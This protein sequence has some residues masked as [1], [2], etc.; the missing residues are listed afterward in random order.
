[1]TL[2]DNTNANTS[3]T[4]TPKPLNFIIALFPGFQ[5]LDLTGPLDILN[6][7]TL[8]PF[9]QPLTLTFL[10]TTLDPVPTKPIPPKSATYTYDLQSLNGTGEVGVGFNQ[11]ITPDA[12]FAG[13]LADLTADR[14]PAEKRPDILLIPGG[15]G[16]RL[17]RLTQTASGEE[18]S[19][20]IVDLIAW[21]PRVV[22]HLR[23]GIMTVCTGSDIL[24]RSGVMEG[25]RATT[26]M[27]RFEDVA[28]RN[29]GVQWVKGARWVRSCAGEGGAGTT[30]GAEGTGGSESVG[31]DKEIWTSAGISAGM[32]LTLAFAAEYYGG[33]EVSREVARRLEYDW[34][35]PGEG[36]VCRFYGRYFRV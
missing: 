6:I 10:S 35:E 14:M 30:G 1:M 3:T 15:L 24:A 16:S 27:L 21:I 2:S 22:P 19:L 33:M 34:A 36:E 18:S 8:P 5:L 17:L 29:K 23:T 26:N 25:R 12:T 20:N 4:S 13:Y 9:S 7:L 11:H 31:K 32:D 28:G